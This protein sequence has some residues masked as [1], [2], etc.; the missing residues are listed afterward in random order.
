MTGKSR[1]R[2]R[3]KRKLTVVI[4]FSTFVLVALVL[5]Y[6]AEKL[7]ELSGGG[8]RAGAEKQAASTSTGK[9]GLKDGNGK[10]GG[11]AAPGKKAR[12]A[13][14]KRTQQDAGLQQDTTENQN[15]A[16]NQEETSNRDG[17]SNQEE[18]KRQAVEDTDGSTEQQ[19]QELLG[20]MTLKEKVAQMFFTT[21]ESVTGVGTVIQTG[22]VSKKAWSEY[23]VG[24]FV[25]FAQNLVSP[26]QTKDMLSG[27]QDYVKGQQG[28]PIFLGVDEEGGRV[29]RIG[30]NPA[31]GV[32]KIEAM[33]KL[34]Q[35]K[36]TRQI[37]K[38]AG[39]IGKYLSQLGFNVDFAPDA[40]VL[41]NPD[42][43]VIGDRSF[44]Q[45]PSVTADMSLA[46][47]K[48][49]AKH[50][51]L[52]CYKHF[53]GHGG[54]VEDSHA[55][56]AYSY[57]TL[58]ELMQSELVPF[59]AGSDH[60]AAFIMVSHISVPEVTGSDVPASLS[61]TLVTDVLRGKIGYQGIIIKDS[62]NMGAVSGNYSM[63]QAA[64]MAVQAG[65]DMLLMSG[66]F[67]TAYGALLQ[68]VQNGTVTEERVD[69]SV[70]RIIRAKLKL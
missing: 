11:S 39:Y 67:K 47:S 26:Q 46:Y 24:G 14:Q 64:V 52:D 33:G 51:I 30:S 65:C 57:Q 31:F 21:P 44:S 29:L 42:N 2:R 8:Q 60:G 50:G 38:A 5:Y 41:T 23:P 61:K 58:E 16:S 25:Y 66:E 70:R 7:A 48:G 40:D 4:L 9:E 34:A 1:R 69:E 49:L 15:E 56:Y 32:E 55:G 3:R 36:D 43:Q 54:T 28:L 59:Q 35:G 6:G 45:D 22:E 13:A 53:P 19:V 20:Q 63:E 10:N 27:I 37:R 17:A 68:A 12:Q 62:L 18:N